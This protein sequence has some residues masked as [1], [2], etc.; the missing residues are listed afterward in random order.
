MYGEHLNAYSFLLKA[1][2]LPEFYDLWEDTEI[3]K[4]EG[5]GFTLHFLKDSALS[6][7]P[8]SFGKFIIA[9]EIL[10]RDKNLIGDNTVKELS[11]E[12]GTENIKMRNGH[13]II[14]ILRPELMKILCELDIHLFI[15]NSS[16]HS[17]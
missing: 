11:I 9:N 8:I 4:E 16:Y 10:L 17:R 14:Y 5:H 2:Y 12:V 15:S 6:A 3:M 7:I 13:K 1:E